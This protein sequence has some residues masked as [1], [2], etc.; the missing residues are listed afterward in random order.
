MSPTIKKEKL[1]QP[2]QPLE[3]WTSEDSGKETTQES[4]GNTHGF[5]GGELD[6]LFKTIDQL[7]ECGVSEDISL[8]QVCHSYLPIRCLWFVGLIVSL[9]ARCCWRSI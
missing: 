4:F 6:K 5:Q 7:R 1:R 9:V 2:Q 3:A 8:P